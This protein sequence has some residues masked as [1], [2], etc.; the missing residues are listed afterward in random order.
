MATIRPPRMPKTL[1][2]PFNTEDLQKLIF[3][4]NHDNSPFLGARNKAIIMVFLD[5]GIRLSE[6]AGMQL[7][8]LDFTR[9]II[10]I[11]GKGAKERVVAIQQRTQKALLQYLLKRNDGYRCV[12]VSEERRPLTDWGIQQ[13]IRKLGIQAGPRMCDALPIPF[14]TPRLLLV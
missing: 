6:I 11:M 14:A 1:I 7:D 3:L 9:G 2:K 10:K 5:T 4:C 13:M 12:W 8:D